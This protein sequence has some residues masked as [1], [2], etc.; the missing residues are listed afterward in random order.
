MD[1]YHALDTAPAPVLT[2]APQMTPRALRTRLVLLVAGVLLPLILLIALVIAGSYF[3][4]KRGAENLVL[5][6]AQAAMAAVDNEIRNE[7]AALEVL[8][9]L[10][11]LQTGNFAGFD[12]DVRRFLTRFPEG[13]N[14]FVTDVTTQAVYTTRLP[15]G[16]P[17]PKRNGK[18]AVEEVFR[19]NRPYVADVFL[20]NVSKQPVFSIDVPVRRDGAVI[21]DLAFSPPRKIFFDLLSQQNIPKEWYIAI[22]DRQGH[23]VAR[24]PALPG[25]D[26][27]SAS[28]SLIPQLSVAG[29]R[30]VDSISLEGTPLLAAIAHSSVGGWTVALGIPY[31]AING[32]AQRMMFIAM[33]FSAVILA[34]GIFVAT[35]M[36]AQLTRAE[37]HREL[38]ANELNHRVKNTLSIV[39]SIVGRGL[40]DAPGGEKYRQA[41]EARLLALSAAHN[42]LGEQNWEQADLRAIATSIIAPYIGPGPRQSADVKGPEVL[43]KP[44]VA[45][46]LAMILNELAT[47]ASKYGAL[48]APTGRVTVRWQQIGA[49]RL[50]L[51]W[52]ESGG[53]PAGLPAKTGYGTKFIERA[54]SGELGGTY[55]ATY[56]TQGLDCAIE[57][58]L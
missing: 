36:A 19:R 42:I 12:Q 10:P 43:L 40:R 55:T 3:R 44:R 9:L 23:H 47:N 37:L 28:P 58:A 48:S 56:V 20:G 21:Y 6:N 30:I 35:R 14:L 41:I 7:I 34:L 18:E 52:T 46:A 5:R 29:D 8:A 31:D 24:L 26:V 38:L 2:P 22:F 17:L 1:T 4:G 51:T 53:P 32:P 49:D 50:R 15:L 57:I 45:I 27:T 13:T 39:Q 11:D 33:A 16:A 54:V 25:N